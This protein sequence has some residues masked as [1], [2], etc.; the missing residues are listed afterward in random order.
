MKKSKYIT[1]GKYENGIL[2]KMDRTLREIE[3]ELKDQ[4]AR[5]DAIEARLKTLTDK[6]ERMH[7]LSR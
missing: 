5:L 7:A 1:V 4:N 2:G 3:Q 6:V